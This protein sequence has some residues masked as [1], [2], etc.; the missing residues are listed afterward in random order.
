MKKEINLEEVELVAQ[1]LLNDYE[2][3]VDSIAERA[4]NTTI[5]LL[6]NMHEGKAPIHN[7]MEHILSTFSQKELAY[8]ALCDFSSTLSKSIKH[9]LK[10]M[11]KRDDK[12]TF[13]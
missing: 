5:M 7:I 4:N 8:M 2:I 10:D 3:D 1:Q 6:N 13:S 9:D 11:K 12:G